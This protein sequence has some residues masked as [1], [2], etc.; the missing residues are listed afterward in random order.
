M[1]R[2]LGCIIVLKGA[3]TVVSDGGRTWTNTTG[4]PCMATAGTGDVLTGVIAALAAQFVGPPPPAGIPESVRSRLP[5]PP[6]R[7]LDLFDAAR[8]A[9]HA[10]GLAGERWAAGRAV[11]AG[12]LAPELADEIPAALETLRTP[13]LP[14][15]SGPA[16]SVS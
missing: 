4:H 2:R 11:A 3:G 8:L 15:P 7:P 9:V 14:P 1:A 13:P 12:L 5:R 10:H 16:Q 6:G